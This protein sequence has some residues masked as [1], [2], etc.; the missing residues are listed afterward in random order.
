MTQE[1]NNNKNNVQMVVIIVLLVVIAIMGFFLWKNSAGVNT[2][3]INNN[4]TSTATNTVTGTYDN[5]AIT[6]IDDKR[7][8]N[9]PTDAILNQLKQ[10]PSIAWAE[11]VRKDFSDSWVSDYLKKNNVKALPLIAFS[12]NNF[13]VSKDPV[14]T[15]QS[16]KPVPKVNNYLQK[17]PWW[18]YTLDIRASFDPFQERSKNGFL[19]LDKAKLKAIKDNSYL[20]GNKDAKITWLEYSDLECPFCAKLHNSG[21][22][23]EL[24]A[25]YGDDLNRVFNHFPLSFHN[26]AQNWAEILECLGEQKGSTAFYA[27]AKKAYNDKKSDKSF[28]IDEAVKLWADKTKLEKCLSDGKYTDKVKSEMNT[29]ASLFGITGTPG[30]ILINNETWEY[31]IISWAYPTASFEKIIDKLLSK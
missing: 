23:E 31:E 9:C 12:T 8:T 26:N 22:P 11:I 6:V 13:D 21:T 3:N 7:C 20:E 10:L 14:Q 4:T 28:L 1:N 17:L 2:S 15:D 27:L 25:K 30:N 18:E 5:L 16:G 24:K 29:G 19:M